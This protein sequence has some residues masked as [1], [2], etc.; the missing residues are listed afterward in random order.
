MLVLS[1]VLAL[2]A[3]VAVAGP[4]LDPGPGEGTG[5]QPGAAPAA[6]SPGA[7]TRW[8]GWQ[9][10]VAD[11]GVAALA[12][13]THDGKW[14]FLWIGTGAIVHGA[15]SH[16]HLALLS[17][18]ARVGLPFLGMLGGA[19]A[20]A[21]CQGELCALGDVVAGGVIGI[22]VAEVLDVATATEDLGSDRPHVAAR[23]WTPVVGALRSGATLGVVGRF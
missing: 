4:A 2:T 23:G 9:I 15:H 14:L 5:A 13:G 22:G 21:G 19:A 17:V 8:Y 6:P 7:E 1:I 11:G 12:A 18:L 20:S 10:L 3:P 16:A